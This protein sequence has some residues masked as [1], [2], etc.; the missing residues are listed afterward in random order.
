MKAA[1]RLLFVGSISLV[2]YSIPA[3]AEPFLDGHCVT[4][5]GVVLDFAIRKGYGFISYNGSPAQKIYS[6]IDKGLA[7]II[8]I[9]NVGQMKLVMNYQT[10]RG[11]FVTR[12]DNQGIT[13]E[14][15]VFCQMKMSGE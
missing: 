3:H 8:N 13:A 4:D 6:Y 14:G 5:Q 2:A 11:Y 15:N 9:G 12:K 10:G 1:H 7:T